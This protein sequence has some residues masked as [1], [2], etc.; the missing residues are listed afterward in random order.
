MAR[1]FLFRSVYKMEPMMTKPFYSSRIIHHLKDMLD[2]TVALHSDKVAFKLR[3]DKGYNKKV[4]FRKYKEDIYNLGT[5]LMDLGIGKKHV[6][7][8]GENRYEWCV[9]YMAV[10]CGGGVI[11]PLDKE[12][13][14]PELINLLKRSHSKGI[15][16]SGKFHDTMKEALKECSELKYAINMDAKVDESDAL[17][18]FENMLKKGKSIIDGGNE[19]YGRIKIEEE[20]LAGIFFTSGTTDLAKGVMLTHKNLAA[21][22]M[23]GAAM[24]DISPKDRILSILPIHH[25]YEGTCGFLLMNSQGA[26]IHFCEG[27][28]H[29]SKNMQE[30]KPTIVL[31]VPLMLDNMYKKVW[32]QID[33]KGI[34]KKVNFALGL[35][36]I[37]AKF[38][39]DIKK[40]IFKD[41]WA[42]FGGEV[43]M[44]VA[45]AAAV[46]PDVMKGF[47][48]FGL[49]V[50]QGYGLTE[51]SPLVSVNPLEASIDSSIGLPLPEAYAEIFE[52]DDKGI[53]EIRVKSDS[54]MK[55]YYENQA[56]TD[57][58][59]KDGWLYTGDIGYRDNKGY[60]YITGRKKNVIV[61]KN[62]KNIFPEEVESYINKSPYILESV[63]YGKD[64]PKETETL[65]CAIVV[66]NYEEIKTFLNKQE[67]SADEVRDLL[68]SEIK[69]YN[70][71]MSTYKMVKEFEIRETEFEKT[72]TKKIKR[73]D[74]LK[75]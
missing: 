74:A 37:L 11:I 57:E 12:L 23:G 55:G 73:R 70:K 38:N 50:I 25:T 46:D 49:K 45:G 22:V 63:V 75:K 9:T 59:L 14:K 28:K 43:R 18:S 64:L 42:A 7:V 60:F 30:V 68:D 69:K 10:T 13:P 51:S 71:Q 3:D 21:N 41:V 53:G 4:T 24:L 48:G 40:K 44:F 56:A 67:V 26:T 62:G 31:V 2:Q 33:K 54:V 20:Q 36:N 1:K 39:I 65:V 29:I 6:A 15:I 61:T 35:S 47:R 27:L 72:T 66:P 8:I 58:V 34:R 32:A 52:P 19:S 16:Y 17:L 5:A